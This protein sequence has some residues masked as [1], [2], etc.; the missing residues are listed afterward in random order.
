MSH[1]VQKSHSELIKDPKARPET[2][3]LLEETYI[4]DIWLGLQ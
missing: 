2:L 3:K 4:Q 1:P